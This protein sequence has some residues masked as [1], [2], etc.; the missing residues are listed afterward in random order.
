MNKKLLGVLMGAFVIWCTTLAF[1]QCGTDIKRT[2]Q[3]C[4]GHCGSVV[5]QTCEGVGS[6]CED[7]TG[8][9]GFGCCGLML[10][11]PGSC[12]A[13]KVRSPLELPPSQEFLAFKGALAL[14][15]AHLPGQQN[16]LVAS[17]GA[18]K[19]AFNDWLE[20]KLKQQRQQGN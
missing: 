10:I 20:T 19:N 8:D 17:C 16:L 7:G 13:A 3:T 15:R 14:R 1:S 6:F 12:E 4:G 18:N 2:T 11:E 9:F 5:M